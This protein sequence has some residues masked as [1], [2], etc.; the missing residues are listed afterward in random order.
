MKAVVVGDLA[1]LRASLL[2]LGWGAVEEHDANGNV[3]RTIAP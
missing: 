1:S 3:V 2:A